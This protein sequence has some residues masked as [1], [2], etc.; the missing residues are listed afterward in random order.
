DILAEGRHVEVFDLVADLVDRGYDLAEF[1]VGLLEILRTLLRLKL[2]PA[3]EVELPEGM[4]EALLERTRAFG[5]ADIVRM[6]GAAAELE[7]QGT[8]RR[9][10]NPRILVEMLLLRLSYMDRTVRIEDLLDALGGAGPGG[11]A[12]GGGP[13]AGRGGGTTPATRARAAGAGGGAGSAAA[14][15]PTPREPAAATPVPAAAPA[16]RAAPPRP[17]TPLPVEETWARWLEDGRGVPTGLSAFLRSS[18]VRDAGGG[19]VRIA[20]LPGPAVERLLEPAV[21]AAIRAGLEPWLGR[22]PEVEV[23]VPGEAPPAT[24]RITEEE[25]RRD[26]LSALFRQEPRLRRAVQELDLE[27]MD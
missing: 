12:E 11:G 24:A 25:V 18:T 16:P 5:A 10:E 26:T 27:L 1:H 19:R 13:P 7:V 14:A 3:S 23:D 15:A 17:S 9:S 2:E 4:R 22:A 20:P 8:L 6:L 21:Q